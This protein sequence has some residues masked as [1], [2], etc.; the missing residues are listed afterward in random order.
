MK[1][2]LKEFT[3]LPEIARNLLESYMKVEAVK[4]AKKLVEEKKWKKNAS[5]KPTIN[6]MLSMCKECNCIKDIED[7]IQERF[8]KISCNKSE[9]NKI[10]TAILKQVKEEFEKGEIDVILLERFYQR[11][12]LSPFYVEEKEIEKQEI[13][14]LQFCLLE[15]KYALR[16][17]D[18]EDGAGD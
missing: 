5:C 10:A 16:R 7:C 8:G 13:K 17:G 11:F 18:V 4:K 3:F 2:E 14:Y 6:N 15:I 1:A 12:G 9:K